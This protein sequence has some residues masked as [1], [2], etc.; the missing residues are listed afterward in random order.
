MIETYT[1]NFSLIGSLEVILYETFCF[2]ILYIVLRYQF[3]KSK[4]HYTATSTDL[5]GLKFFVNVS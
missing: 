2:H 5:I 3:R 1:E 4:I